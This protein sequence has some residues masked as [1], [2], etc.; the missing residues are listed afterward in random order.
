MLAIKLAKSLMEHMKGE[1]DPGGYN[2]IFPLGIIVST[3][4]VMCR[5]GTRDPTMIEE[6][7][8]AANEMISIAGPNSPPQLY[9]RS[10]DAYMC[11]GMIAENE[12][13]YQVAIDYFE[14]VKEFSQKQNDASSTKAMEFKLSQLRIKLSGDNSEGNMIAEA[15]TDLQKRYQNIITESGKSSLFAISTGGFLG[16]YLL[17]DG[18]TIEAQR[19]LAELA[20]LSQRVHG[21]DHNATMEVEKFLKCAQ[22]RRVA[23][24]SGYGEHD[25]QALRFDKE[26]ERYTVKGPIL[27]PRRE[28]EE[29]TF[30]V[31]MNEILLGVAVPMLLYGLKSATHLNG[32]V[33]EIR[34]FRGKS[35]PLRYEIHFEDEGLKPVIVKGNNLRIAFDLPDT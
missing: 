28:D 25:F 2:K 20:T 19:L 23:I 24:V 21:L 35:M 11:L 12:D 9:E 5:D 10:M 14:T 34:G 4:V 22:E 29:E 18:R 6:G 30:P 27:D 1:H 33:G 16:H 31:A 7:N 13:R 3:V 8:R 32:K 26:T 15:I 17:K